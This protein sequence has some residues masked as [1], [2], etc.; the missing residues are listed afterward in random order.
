MSDEMGDIFSPGDQFH[1]YVVQKQL[2]K[3]GNGAVYL[4]HHE[5]LDALYALKVLLDPE[6]QTE[7][8]T[9]VKRFLREARLASRIRHPNLVSVHDCGFDEARGLYYLVMDYVPGVSLR[10]TIALE[11]RIAPERA[12][13]VVAQVAAA[14]DAA[15]AFNVVHRDIKPENILVQP[16]GRVKLVD[17]GIA[18]AQNLGDTLRTNTDN[19]F[20]TPSYISPEQA[21]CSADV[22]TRADIYSLGIVF[23]EMLT[24]KCPYEGSTASIFEQILSEDQI[25][26]VRD[27][28]AGVPPGLAVLIRRMTIKDR[29]RRIASFDL[30][31]KEL[32]KLGFGQSAGPAYAAEYAPRPVAGMKTLLDGLGATPSQ[33]R[34]SAMLGKHAV[35]L[36][37]LVVLG[38]VA[39]ALFWYNTH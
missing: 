1:G 13:G 33:E 8:Q 6:V 17:L 39:I 4:V 15:Q 28:I 37:L 5:V 30:V 21:Q 24:G 35:P 31:L 14:L 12:A 27:V 32:E 26:D 29:S 18:K 9:Y 25:P 23:F 22:D 38:L 3:G 16:D 2:G 7:D 34:K 36:W 11:G 19:I 10:A 20:G